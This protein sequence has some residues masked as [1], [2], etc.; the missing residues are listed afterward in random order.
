MVSWPHLLSSPLL[1]Q[2]ESVV[3][4]MLVE[5]WK[6]ETRGMKQHYTRTKVILTDRDFISSNYGQK[7]LSLFKTGEILQTQHTKWQAL[8]C[9][10]G[11]CELTLCEVGGMLSPR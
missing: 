9:R 2:R 3:S 4:G 10:H 11:H 5:G 6:L 7:F 1:R 8:I